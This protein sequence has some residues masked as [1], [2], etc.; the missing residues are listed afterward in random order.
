MLI[1]TLQTG[2]WI[3]ITE[4]MLQFVQHMRTIGAVCSLNG[5]KGAHWS[6]WSVTGLSFLQINF[7]HCE[8]ATIA[9]ADYVDRFE[10][11]CILVQDP[12][13]RGSSICGI[14]ADWI[15]FTSNNNNSSVLFTKK[16]YTVVSSLINDN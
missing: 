7:H 16:D 10:I 6:A 12:Y 15:V 2:R 3:V 4:L 9:L 13:V 14:P 11:D 1:A 5:C 8:E